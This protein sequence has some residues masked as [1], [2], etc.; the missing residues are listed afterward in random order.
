MPDIAIDPRRIGPIRLDCHNIEAVLFDQPARNLR[1]CAVKF[2][3]AVARL[4]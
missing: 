2:R 4:A 1:P 3:G